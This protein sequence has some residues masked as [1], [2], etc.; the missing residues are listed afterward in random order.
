MVV[1]NMTGAGGR[2]AMNHVYNLAEKTGTVIGSFVSV[3]HL[4]QLFGDPGIQFELPKFNWLGSL[5]DNQMACYANSSTGVKSPA[6]IIGPSGKTLQLGTQQPGASGGAA[7]MVL[8]K[9]KLGAKL[10]IITGYA[11]APELFLA[12]EKGEIDG[13]CL[14]WEGTWATRP[15]LF[16][17]QAPKANVF[18]QFGTRKAQ[19]LSHVPLVGEFIKTDDT[20]ALFDLLDIGLRIQR[21]YALPPGVPG[22]RMAALRRAFLDTTKDREFIAE[23][24]KTG[25]VLAPKTFDEVEQIIGTAMKTPKSMVD[26]LK[27]ITTSPG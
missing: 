11:G 16:E 2:L 9:E 4:E 1:E 12:M 15:D 27:R 19:D 21:V 3:P 5:Q 24:T 14:S 6:D 10:N 7:Y 26:E 18:V 22:E 13:T 20:R 8:L 25:D 17:G 23:T